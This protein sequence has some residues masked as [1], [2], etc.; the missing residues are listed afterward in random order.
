MALPGLVVGD[1]DR[2]VLHFVELLLKREF[3][4]LGASTGREALDLVSGQRPLLV[5]L[6]SR[7][8]EMS[9]LEAL[10][11][12]RADPAT[13]TL[14]VFLMSSDLNPA[15]RR[16]VLAAGADGFLAKPFTARALRSLLASSR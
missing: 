16:E 5:L 14:P 7:M 13:R 3:Q 12:L 6:D 9:G 11:C 15:F 2:H 4:V 8:P 1:D 10:R